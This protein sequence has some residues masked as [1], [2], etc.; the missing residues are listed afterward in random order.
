MIE[1]IALAVALIAPMIALAL[2]AAVFFVAHRDEA[3]RRAA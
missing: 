1:Q 2:A 3:R